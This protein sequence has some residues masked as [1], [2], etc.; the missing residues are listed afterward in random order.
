M[1]EVDLS[2]ADVHPD[3]A[4][5]IHPFY[6][7]LLQA[8][9]S[10]IHSIH[11]TGS[12]ATAAYDPGY[13]DVNS[14]V[15]LHEMDLTFLE[16]LAPLGKRYRKKRVRA[17]LIMTPAYVQDSLDV[18]PIEFQE[19]ALIHRTVYGNDLFVHLTIDPAHLRLQCE[20][21]LKA[22]LIGL[23]QGYLSSQGEAKILTAN[24]AQ[25]ISGYMPLFRGIIAL[26]GRTPPIAQEDVIGMLQEVTGVETSIYLTVLRNK[27]QHAR[28]RMP[29]LN[30][31]FE[32]YYVTTDAL[33]SVVDALAV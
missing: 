6:E 22:K 5:R 26:Y 25:A 21:D 8:N 9:A 28:L 24:F 23:R 7:A 4:T 19:I 14:V 10:L 29:A 33:R 13:S 30:A 12:V 1:S 17:P 3:A 27:R 20:R 31:L 11:I 18:F 32:T 16:R 15:V 2:F